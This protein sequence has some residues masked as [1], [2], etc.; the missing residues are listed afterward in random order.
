MRLRPIRIRFDRVAAVRCVV[1]PERMEDAL[2]DLVIEKIAADRVRDIADQREGDV[3]IAIAIADAARQRHFFEFFDELLI[4]LVL[5]E[6][7]VVGV[8]RQSD[9]LAQD[10]A[11][12]EVVAGRGIVKLERRQDAG[13]FRLPAQHAFI[14]EH[15]GECACERFRQRG[16][17]EH[18]VR[19]H[20]FAATRIGPA[21]AALKQNGFVA[22]DRG[23][24]SRHLIRRGDLVEP[25]IEI[26]SDRFRI[27]RNRGGHRRC[28]MCSGGRMRARLH[29]P[30]DRCTRIGRIHTNQ[31]H[32]QNRQCA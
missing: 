32:Q 6:K 12:G 19:R 31:H 9:A 25:R 22:D 3:L 21:D 7:I 5:F 1:H 15:R 17:T 26:R 16:Q 27:R 11:H 29:R 24:E 18:A 23:G 8:V 13:D 4:R 28:L 2:L 30:A 10:V 20:R 14:D